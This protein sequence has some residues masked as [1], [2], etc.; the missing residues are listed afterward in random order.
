MVRSD[1]IQEIAT[2]V[3]KKEYKIGVEVTGFGYLILNMGK[4]SNNNYAAGEEISIE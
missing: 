1:T 4:I 3:E 2:E